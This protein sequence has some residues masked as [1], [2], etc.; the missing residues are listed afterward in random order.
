MTCRKVVPFLDDFADGSL[1][2]SLSEKIQKHISDCAKCGNRLEGTRRLKTL[3][4]SLVIPEP[5]SQYF[6]DTTDLI[7][8]R[9]TDESQ[10]YRRVH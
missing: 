5:N 4:A 2:E 7:L 9:V 6:R 10:T 1:D 3:L 8:T